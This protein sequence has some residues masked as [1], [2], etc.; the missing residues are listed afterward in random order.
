MRARAYSVSD[1]MGEINRN[2][3][4]VWKCGV[5]CL[6][7]RI[8]VRHKAAIGKGL[9]MENMSGKKRGAGAGNLSPR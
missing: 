5:V 8:G 7:P 9:R 6:E 2:Y 1:V 4:A 3:E